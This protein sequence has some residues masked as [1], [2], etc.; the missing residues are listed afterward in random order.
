MF[1]NRSVRLYLTS[2]EFDDWCISEFNNWGIPIPYFVH[3][4]NGI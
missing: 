2:D 4:D 3:K 1:L